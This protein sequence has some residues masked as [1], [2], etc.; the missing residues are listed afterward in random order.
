MDA[1]SKTLTWAVSGSGPEEYPRVGDTR[2][3]YTAPRKAPTFFPHCADSLKASRTP[4]KYSCADSPP[5]NTSGGGNSIS[6]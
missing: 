5:V 1:G 6:E 4:E 3:R 2:Y